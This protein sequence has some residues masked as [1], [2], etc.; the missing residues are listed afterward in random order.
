MYILL[1]SGSDVAQQRLLALLSSCPH[2]F[3]QMSSSVEVQYSCETCARR[4]S[5]CGPF[6]RN[7]ADA[8]EQSF[9]KNS[10]TKCTPVTSMDN[11]RTRK[12]PSLDA[13]AYAAASAERLAGLYSKQG[14]APSSKRSKNMSAKPLTTLDVSRLSTSSTALVVSTSPMSSSVSR[15]I[16]YLSQRNHLTIR[17]RQTSGD[18]REASYTAVAMDGGLAVDASSATVMPASSSLLSVSRVT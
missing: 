8:H 16:L 7:E 2:R 1:L 13:N 9:H 15:V 3:N 17:V 10:T 4:S 14:A 12:S 6:N 5:P 11:V 18:H